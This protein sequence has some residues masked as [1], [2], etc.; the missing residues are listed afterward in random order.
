[1]SEYWK[2]TPK[3][4]C[5]HCKVYVRDTKLEKANHESTG[6]HKGALEKYLRNIHKDNDREEREKQRAKNEVARLNGS[7]PS[8]GSEPVPKATAAASSV[9]KK[10]QATADERKA[11]IAQLAA[12]GVAVPEQ[13]RRDMAMAGDWETVRTTRIAKLE[14]QSKSEGPDVKPA[15]GAVGFKRPKPELGIDE[16]EPVRKRFAWG[17][18]TKTYG[19]ARKDDDLD[20]LLGSATTL[21]KI[22]VE[23]EA[24]QGETSSEKPD[25]EP[26]DTSAVIKPEPNPDEPIQAEIAAE[27]EPV[28]PEPAGDDSDIIFKKRKTKSKK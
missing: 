6:K 25:P 17:S 27:E 15:P 11:Q 4:W 28:E 5:D 8:T 10:R 1:M 19:D 2:S 24:G 16:E 13:F 26:T 21:K 20:A 9:D 14:A 3:Y 7:A 23:P 12:M 18:A 22:K